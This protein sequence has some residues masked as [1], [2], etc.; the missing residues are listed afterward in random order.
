MTIGKYFIYIV[1]VSVL[2]IAYYYRESIEDHI[3]QRVK[4]AK[5]AS[6]ITDDRLVDTIKNA[7]EK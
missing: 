7:V 4:D 6:P 5:I 1:I 3:G 2:L